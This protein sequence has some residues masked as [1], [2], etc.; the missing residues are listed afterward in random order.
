MAWWFVAVKYT[1]VLHTVTNKC[2]NRKT[3]G[4]KTDGMA[5]G[6]MFWLFLM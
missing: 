3:D 5:N 2:K 4:S 1:F 6:S